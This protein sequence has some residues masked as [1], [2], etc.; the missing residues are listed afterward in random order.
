MA[1]FEHF[2]YTNFHDLNLDQLAKKI[3]EL[4]ELK[5]AIEE[6]QTLATEL[7]E[8]MN[9][10]NGRIDN[11]EDLYDTFVDTITAK[12]TA[13]Q[14]SLEDDID[15]LKQ[16]LQNQMDSYQATVDLQLT[17]F[18]NSVS[19]LDT[20]LT[21]VLANLPSEIKMISPFTGQ[22]SDL[23]TI[24]AELSNQGR[25]EALTATEYDALTKTATAYDAYNLTAY[26]YDWH[27]KTLLV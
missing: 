11:I 2:P 4:E 3:E 7:R 23:A 8:E 16:D 14:T 1:L 19:A 10:V 25:S 13:L 21:N 22:M 12:F 18:G 24:I 20:R 6:V 27:G 9:A 26:Q 5:N 15:L 17:T